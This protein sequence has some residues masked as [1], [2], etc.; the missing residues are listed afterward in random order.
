LEGGRAELEAA[1]ARYALSDAMLSLAEAA[2][3]ED[4]DLAYQMAVGKWLFKKL[5]RNL[6]PTA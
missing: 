5:W 2:A 6:L 4:E 3:P 1:A